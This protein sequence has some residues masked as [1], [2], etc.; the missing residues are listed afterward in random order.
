MQRSS[1][2]AMKVQEVILRVGS[3]DLVPFEVC[4]FSV[5]TREEPQTCKR[6]RSDALPSLLRDDDANAD[7]SCIREFDMAASRELSRQ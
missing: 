1:D 2:A 6:C 3:A 7:R 5:G 4:G